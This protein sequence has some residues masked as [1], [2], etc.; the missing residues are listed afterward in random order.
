MGIARHST[1]NKAQRFIR[2]S[3]EICPGKSAKAGSF[4]KLAVTSI[5]HHHSCGESLPR[6]FQCK[7]NLPLRRLGVGE[8]PEARHRISASIEGGKIVGVWRREVCVVQDIEKLRPELNIERFR[9]S[10]HAGI[11][12]HRE[13]YVK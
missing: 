6:Q 5:F 9:N 12:D 1:S 8:L 13:V 3:R 10:R 2:S 11:F 4:S 7:L